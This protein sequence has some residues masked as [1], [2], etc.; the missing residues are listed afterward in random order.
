MKCCEDC[1]YHK[2]INNI[3]DIVMKCEKADDEHKEL[4]I[5]NEENL[6]PDWCP[7]NG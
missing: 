7:L 2:W 6:I 4:N 5:L 3:P 1:D